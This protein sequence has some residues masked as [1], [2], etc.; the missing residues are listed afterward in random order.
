[1]ERVEADD[2]LNDL[3]QTSGIVY[4]INDGAVR[5]SPNYLDNPHGQ[6]HVAHFLAAK[7]G[8]Q[9]FSVNPKM[10]ATA[11]DDILVQV[12]F[13]YVLGFRPPAFDGKIHKLRVELTTDANQKL[14]ATR[15]SFRPAYIALT[16]K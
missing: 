4:G 16:N 11:L 13:R 10:F 3:L 6:G 7:T 12:H 8:G 14:P 1:M 15:L 2:L 9:F 5:V